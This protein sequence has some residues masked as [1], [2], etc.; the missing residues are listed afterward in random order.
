MELSID[1]ESYLRRVEIQVMKPF[2]QI[3]FLEHI[4]GELI[5]SFKNGKTTFDQVGELGNGFSIARSIGTARKPGA[6]RALSRY[7]VLVKVEQ[8]ESLR[9]VASRL[10]TDPA[11]D[12]V[13][14]NY[15]MRHAATPNDPQLAEQWALPNIRIRRLENHQGKIFSS[16]SRD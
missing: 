10:A 7:L 5:V 12:F 9:E 3:I 6:G 16:C 15:V 8:E 13:E 1:P 4:A 2:P 14:P 11:V